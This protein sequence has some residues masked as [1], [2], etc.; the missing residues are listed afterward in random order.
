MSSEESLTTYLARLV[1][2]VSVLSSLCLALCPG[3]AVAESVAFFGRS[4]QVDRLE[5]LPGDQVKVDV[6]GQTFI[7]SRQGAGQKVF[8]IYAE[9]PNLLPIKSIDSEYGSFV[10]SLVQHGAQ[11]D[12]LAAIQAL[13]TSQGI[14]EQVREKFFSGVMSSGAGGDLVVN[15]LRGV[16]SRDPQR[17]AA[18]IALPSLPLHSANQAQKLL[19]T[20]LTWITLECPQQ[21]IQLAQDELLRGELDQGALT[22]SFVGSFFKGASEL[23][24]AAESSSERLGIVRESITS[25]DANK[26]EAALRG[27]SFDPLLRGYYQKSLGD[28][29]AEFGSDALSRHRPAAVL[30]SLALLDFSDR[31]NRHHELLL[32]ALQSLT[33]E[34]KPV[35]TK[36]PV[37]RMLWAYAT[38]DQVLKDEYIALLSSG[39]EEAI[40]D[41]QP[42]QGALYVN[43][44]KDIRLD[45]SLQNDELR[46]LVAEGFVDT[47]DFV[48]AQGIMKEVQ[49]SIPWVIRFRLLLKLDR[50]VLLMVLLGGLVVARWLINGIAMYKRGDSVSSQKAKAKPEDAFGKS[51]KKKSEQKRDR[52]DFDLKQSRYKGLD[53][54]A[55]CLAKFQL[56][57]GASLADIK[58]AYR[59]LVKSL[60]PDLNPKASKDDTARFIELTKAYE[61]LIELHEERAQPGDESPDSIN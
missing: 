32:Q 15:A 31:D 5:S 8:R 60:H 55:D 39:I 21:L 1:R 19:S 40:Q 47:G 57:P 4:F 56:Q 50:Y 43:I 38:K 59:A 41:G 51:N 18:C 6:Q 54:Y 36:E 10:A 2:G 33:Y 14:S 53:E 35:F 26:F 34:D 16:N 28:S 27:A 12:A 52:P 9:H 42:A 24:Q 3:K 29:V 13:L 20:D 37:K 11:D 25:G 46:G 17:Q 30:Q 48:A 49:T 7:A 22:L 58:N 45:P 23:A 44:L 61:R